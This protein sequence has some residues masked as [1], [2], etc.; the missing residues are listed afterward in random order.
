MKPFTFC[1]LSGLFL[2]P[3]LAAE[4]V[5]KGTDPGAVELDALSCFEAGGR[6]IMAG[7]HEMARELFEQ[8]AKKGDARCMFMLGMQHYFG[9]AGKKDRRT[10][11]HW[12]EKSME[13]GYAPAAFVLV[14]MHEYGD[15]T[16]KNPAKAAELLRFAAYRCVVPA[17]NEMGA[18]LYQGSDLPENKLA[19]LAWMS[20]AAANPL[21]SDEVRATFTEIVS[22]LGTEDHATLIKLEA[23]IRARLDCPDK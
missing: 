22:Q 21:S 1:L 7:D 20:I 11:R 15:G 3:L 5:G 18:R 17:Q 6:R 14:K 19:G 4:D 12:L 13:N 8:G 16:E 2:S 9:K 23:D 10:A